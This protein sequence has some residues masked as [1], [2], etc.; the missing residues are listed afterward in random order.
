[1]S[2]LAEH[3][4]QYLQLRRALGYTLVR[5]GR[6]LP[7]FVAFVHQAAGTVITTDL[8]L[9]WATQ[10]Q[11]GTPAWAAERLRL[12]RGF[13]RY[14]QAQDPRTEIPPGTLLPAPRRRRGTPYLYTDADVRALMTAAQTTLAP[15]KGATY[16][17]LLGLLASTGLRVGEALALADADCDRAAGVLRIRHAKFGKTRLVLLHPSTCAALTT[18]RHLR[19]RTFRHPRSPTFFVSRAGTRLQYQNVHGT[20]LSLVRTAGLAHQRPRRPR[21]HDLRHSFAVATLRDWYR[22]GVDVD[23]RLPWLSTYLGHVSPSSTYW[24]LTAH[25]DL[26]RLAHRRLARVMEASS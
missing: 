8:A 4:Q 6:L 20:F 9:A 10:S 23:A 22:R 19:D 14:M 3:L 21:L 25:P 13:A 11:R 15:F 18:Y 16:A 7:R 5:A 26:L 2:G 17:T 12:V 1:M 24:Y